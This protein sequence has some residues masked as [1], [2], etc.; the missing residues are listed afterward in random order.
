MG[1]RLIAD[2]AMVAHF[3]FLAY[4][5]VGG[6][7]AWRWPRTILL[8]IATTAYGLLNV[9]VGWPCPLTSVERWG[10][11]QA[12]E[13]TLPASGFI[14]HYLAGVIYPEGAE[15]WARL[16]LAALVV[17]SWVSFALFRPPRTAGRLGA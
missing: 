10:R 8:H 5:A 1:H 16:A 17:I 6:F 7:L 15:T 2:L 14:D 9:I 11:D 12:G 13:A 4:M 3:A